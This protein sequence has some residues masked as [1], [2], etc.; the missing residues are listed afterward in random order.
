M[1]QRVAV[2]IPCFNEAPTV[3]TVVADFAR[4][5]PHATIYVF[6]NNSTDETAAVAARAG[7]VVIPEKRQG[8]GHVMASMLAGVDADVYVLVDGDATYPADRVHDLLDPIARKRA[9]HVVG[10]RR[11]VAPDK[12]YRRFHTFGN[13]MVTFLVNRIFGTALEDV[14]SGYRAFTRDV[15]L[16][17]PILSSGFDVETE[18]TLQTLEK[19]FVIVETPVPYLERPA[20]SVSKLS[21]Y[22]DGARVLLRVATILKDFRPFSFFAGL[23]GVTAVLSLLA[24][25]RPIADYVRE[26]YVYHVPLAILAAVLGVISVGLLQTGIVLAT[27]NARFRELHALRR[28]TRS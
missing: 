15:A 3:A 5:L 27:M 8:K 24:G 9:D 6:D 21:T 12:A 10:A 17:V 18:F 2:L 26:R 16:N 14:M 28:R 1:A 13:R 4:E 7:A 19:G 20:G 11:A 23:A 22:R 25:Y